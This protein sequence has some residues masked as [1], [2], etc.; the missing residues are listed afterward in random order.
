[1]KNEQ[2]PSKLRLLPTWKMTAHDAITRFEATDR[3]EVDHVIASIED[4][5]LAPR[6]T[7]TIQK[8]FNMT[9]RY[10]R[11]TLIA[12]GFAADIIGTRWSIVLA[13]VCRAHGDSRG[14][15]GREIVYFHG[16]SLR[17]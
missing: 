10:P 9:I 17:G 1:M 7:A 6:L 15:S 2:S 12:I 16:K 3:D 8:F 11:A 4:A 13:S 5:T 14:C